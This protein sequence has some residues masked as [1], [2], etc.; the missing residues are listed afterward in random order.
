MENPLAVRGSGYSFRVA[1]PVLRNDCSRASSCLKAVDRDGTVQKILTIVVTTFKSM[2]NV[3][4]C[5]VMR[6]GVLRSNRK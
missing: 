2:I 5:R 4:S 6:R 3:V 1:K